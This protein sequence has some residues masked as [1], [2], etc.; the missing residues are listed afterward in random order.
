MSRHRDEQ[1]SALTRARA[2]EVIFNNRAHTPTS[3]SNPVA[4]KRPAPT[5][6]RRQLLVPAKNY[7]FRGI[8]FS[9]PETFLNHPDQKFSAPLCDIL[10]SPQAS[11]TIWPA[12][13][14]RLAKQI[15]HHADLAAKIT[16]FLDNFFYGRGDAANLASE[17]D[18]YYDAASELLS[19]DETLRIVRYLPP[20]T[21]PQDDDRTPASEQFRAN[22]TAATE[23][24]IAR[25]EY[26]VPSPKF[27]NDLPRPTLPSARLYTLGL[28][29]ST[30]VPELSSTILAA[31]KLS[32]HL[33]DKTTFGVV[34]VRGGIVQGFADAASAPELKIITKDEDNELPAESQLPLAFIQTNPAAYADLVFT[35]LQI[36]QPAALLQL[37]RTLAPIYFH[38][39]DPDVRLRSAITLEQA[40]ITA[41]LHEAYPRLCSPT[42]NQSTNIADETGFRVIATKIFATS[43]FIPNLTQEPAPLLDETPAD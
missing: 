27:Q 6:L 13:D 40:L 1:L 34:L 39:S 42:N 5:T 24:L 29:I 21:F 19:N 32:Y 23:K 36:G 2:A 30:R 4:I 7:D 41:L 43:I 20:E 9:T 15:Q 18:D 26:L 25:E 31:E 33:D 17:R 38:E 16:N 35:S 37:Q 12:E 11:S 10:L 8:R 22:L 3:T 14:E 28:P